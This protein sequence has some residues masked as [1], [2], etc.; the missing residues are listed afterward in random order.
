MK[1]GVPVSS[2]F[3]ENCSITMV[4]SKY[5]LLSALK[6]SN[7]WRRRVLTAAEAFDVLKY[8]R[9]TPV[10]SIGNE[11]HLK[12]VFHLF[13]RQSQAG[14]EQSAFYFGFVWWR[15]CCQAVGLDY[16]LKVKMSGHLKKVRVIGRISRNGV[17]SFVRVWYN[18]I[19]RLLY[20]TFQWSRGRYQIKCSSVHV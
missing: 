10:T 12:A 6:W 17:M 20:N 7:R 19:A 2:T 9:Y 13:S 8:E 1:A 5:R 15:K 3:E 18:Q 16:Y 11:R 14:D 4:W